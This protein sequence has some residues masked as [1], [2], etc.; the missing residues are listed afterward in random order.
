MNVE[1]EGEK[2]N[3]KILLEMNMLRVPT[4]ERKTLRNQVNKNKKIRIKIQSRKY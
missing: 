3:K 4:H 2:T 1:G